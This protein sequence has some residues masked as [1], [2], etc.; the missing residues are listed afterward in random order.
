MPFSFGKKTY[1]RKFGSRRE[2]IDGV[3]YCTSGKLTADCLE[4]K[5]NGK[6]ISRRRSAEAKKRIETQ[7]PFI[8]SEKAWKVRYERLLAKLASE[9]KGV[10]DV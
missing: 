6:I 4:L 2:V 3:A 7:S 10:A 5:P 9:S 1:L 8:T